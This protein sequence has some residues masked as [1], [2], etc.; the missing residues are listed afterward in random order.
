[1]SI[2][3]AVLMISGALCA[4]V[5]RS[6]YAGEETKVPLRVSPPPSPSPVWT[7]KPIKIDR[8][9]ETR[10]RIE[11][12]VNPARTR[13]VVDQFPGLGADAAFT[14]SGRRW[15]IAHVAL[16]DR[17]RTCP[18]EGGRYWPCGVRAWAFVSGLIS[19]A[20]LMCDP[21]DAKEGVIAAVDCRLDERPIAEIIVEAGWADAA[22]AAPDRV[23][24]AARR[25]V[26]AKRGIHATA[27]PR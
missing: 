17:G 16:P 24:E 8:G 25:G 22:P 13:L 18:Y 14:A 10:E 1:M 27:P 3:G 11:P 12:K 21:P 19:G 20:R 4:L 26:A 23:V 7:L 5:V 9:L 6:A 2:A 15:R